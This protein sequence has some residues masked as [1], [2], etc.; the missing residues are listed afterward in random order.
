M[1]VR[2]HVMW[3]SATLALALGTGAACGGSSNPSTATQGTSCV[4]ASAAH[5][6]YVVIEHASA[7]TVQKCVG[8]SADTIDGQSSMVES[9]LKYQSQDFGGSLGKAVCQIDN[10]PMHYDKC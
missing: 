6:A 4:N 7:T 10:E 3:V 5:H 2:K 1:K 8:F 9:G